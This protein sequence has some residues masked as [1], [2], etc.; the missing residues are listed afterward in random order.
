MKL[1]FARFGEDFSVL[2]MLFFSTNSA[3][4]CLSICDYNQVCLEYKKSEWSLENKLIRSI[5]SPYSPSAPPPP[6]KN[7]N[8]AT[9]C[10][11]EEQSQSKEVC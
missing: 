6:I 8:K 11:S 7:N 4:H 9:F 3:H 1:G 5:P 2:P 10:F